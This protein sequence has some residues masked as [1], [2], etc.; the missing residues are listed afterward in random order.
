MRVVG[1][2]PDALQCCGRTSRQR[3]ALRLERHA[4]SHVVSDCWPRA[5]VK[6]F[7]SPRLASAWPLPT[8]PSPVIERSKP[9][10][11]TARGGAALAGPR[12]LSAL[13]STAP[14]IRGDA[15]SSD[16]LGSARRKRRGTDSVSSLGLAKLSASRSPPLHR[17]VRRSCAPACCTAP[18]ISDSVVDCHIRLLPR[19]APE[20]PVLAL[21][22]SLSPSLPPSHSL[23]L[24][25]P[26][27]P[28]LFSLCPFLTPTPP[29]GG[30]LSHRQTQPT[31]T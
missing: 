29:T 31:L 28:L 4:G 7:A 26:P 5:R 30:T 8:A 2:S 6:S 15:D 19:L 11:L 9:P 25:L 17:S 24:S 16:A 1:R 3:P 22:L 23:S 14:R 27:S 13:Q 10:T 12:S 18:A 20:A 21:S